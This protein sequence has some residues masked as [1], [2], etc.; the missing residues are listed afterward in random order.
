MEPFKNLI[1]KRIILIDDDELSNF[2]NHTLIKQVNNDDEISVFE[3]ALEGL[4]FLNSAAVELELI[5]EF[6]FLD[7]SMPVMDGYQFLEEFE[8]LPDTIKKKSKIV[9]L[10]SSIDKEDIERA[11]T[12]PYVVRFLNK[13]LTRENIL[14]L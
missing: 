4:K 2:L 6:I 12:N 14:E 13:P 9:I 8:N 5:P 10:S 1:G 7:I 11:S 3:S